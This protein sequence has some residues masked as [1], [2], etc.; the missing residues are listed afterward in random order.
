MR[1][2]QRR[3]LVMLRE[4]AAKRAAPEGSAEQRVLKVRRQ[5]EVG[6]ARPAAQACTTEEVAAA[7][8]EVGAV[9]SAEKACVLLH[10]VNLIV[11]EETRQGESIGAPASATQQEE[12]AATVFRASAEEDELAALEAEVNRLV[13][14]ATVLGV[15]DCA[16]G[17]APES[18]TQEP[19]SMWASAAM[20]DADDAELTP[21]HARVE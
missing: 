20:A 10:A 4:A 8:E 21:K 14:P 17:G 13:V 15:V 3:R 19:A 11:A 9:D 18:A 5:E 12:P 2:A 6:A 1:D 7:V 16:P